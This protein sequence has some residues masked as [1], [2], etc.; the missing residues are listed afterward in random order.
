M[1]WVRIRRRGVFSF[2]RMCQYTCN[3]GLTMWLSSHTWIWMTNV[4]CKVQRVKSHTECCDLKLAQSIIVRSVLYSSKWMIFFFSELSSLRASTCDD[5]FRKS[6]VL[7][8]SRK[9]WVWADL[10]FFLVLFLLFTF[11]VFR[12]AWTILRRQSEMQRN[13]LL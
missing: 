10:Y 2:I 5:S 8:I 9:I 6:C 3:L 11:S 1:V 13:F 12:N 4:H 7:K